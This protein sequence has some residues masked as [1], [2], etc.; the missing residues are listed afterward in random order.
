MEKSHLFSEN[1]LYFGLN[2][3]HSAAEDFCM[4]SL[5]CSHRTSFIFGLY[6]VHSASVDFCME[7]SLLFSGIFLYVGLNLEHSSGNIFAWKSLICSV[8]TSF[9]CGLI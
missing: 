7:K 3:V 9:M 2:L 4:E 8:T 6:L 5:V 1:F